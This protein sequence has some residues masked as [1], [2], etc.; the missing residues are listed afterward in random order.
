ML[1]LGSMIAFSGRKALAQEV[2][3]MCLSSIITARAPVPHA[4]S[5]GIETH[6]CRF[7]T[8][9]LQRT[10]TH[11]VHSVQLHP[12][13][14]NR[15][16]FLPTAACFSASF[17]MSG[18]AGRWRRTTKSTDGPISS[19]ATRGVVVPLFLNRMTYWRSNNCTCVGESSVAWFKNANG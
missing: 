10:H 19:N 18:G 8:P 3:E 15:T 2:S 16:F 6:G 5:S 11:T 13:L 12:L 7:V 9:S 4:R 14:C 17:S 1:R